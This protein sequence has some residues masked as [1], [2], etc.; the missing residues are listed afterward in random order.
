MAAT[1]AAP[2][3]AATAPTAGCSTAA[4]R[5]Q[6]VARQ[7]AVVAPLQPCPVDTLNLIDMQRGAASRWAV[8]PDG[9]VQQAVGS[10][11]RSCAASLQCALIRAVLPAAAAS[12]C[13]I[14]GAGGAGSGGGV[15]GS[16]G[17]GGE[18][19]ATAGQGGGS[20]ATTPPCSYSAAG[21]DAINPR[22]AAAAGQP[23]AP[24][25]QRLEA[26]LGVCASEL[27]LFTAL[28]LAAASAARSP[29]A[30]DAGLVDDVAAVAAALAACPPL[31]QATIDAC[32][33]QSRSSSSDGGLGLASAVASTTSGQC[34]PASSAVSPEVWSLTSALLPQ[35]PSSSAAA[36]AND[37]AATDIGSSG[38]VTRGGAAS[39]G[40]ITWRAGCSCAQD[41]APV[42]DLVTGQ[43]SPSACFAGCLPPPSAARRSPLSSAEPASSRAAVEEWR[44][45]FSARAAVPTIDVGLAAEARR[46]FL[47]HNAEPPRDASA[48]QM[49]AQ[50]SNG[51]L[52][53]ASGAA[54]F[55]AV[56]ASEPSPA[57]RAGGAV[58]EASGATAATDPLAL[59]NVL[60]AELLH[61]A[62]GL[63]LGA[64]SGSGSSGLPGA[65]DAGA[66]DGGLAESVLA[67][68]LH[69]LYLVA[70]T[71]AEM[72]DQGPAVS[73]QAAAGPEAV[74]AG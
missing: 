47:A 5:D 2:A 16:G 8:A 26:L 39:P 13:A 70:A 17:G 55:T 12:A 3:A 38:G 68:R 50:S 74:A 37:I 7:G 43:Q 52:P 18:S 4:Q 66:G 45:I 20:G 6:R 24:L 60:L 67:R 42:C 72:Q 56:G 59:V 23:P 58:S 48:V 41:W 62:V 30:S 64:G 25:V 28:Q 27:A 71:A 11:A 53:A 35:P 73:E 40:G 54:V 19:G 61:P 29:G 36:T 49:M 44:E 65:A 31:T 22:R 1:A 33:A 34:V 15:G 32:L 63:L 9:L 51:D 14:A 46:P 21:G 57:T 69:L 10:S